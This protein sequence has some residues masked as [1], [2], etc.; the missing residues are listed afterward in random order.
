LLDIV[1]PVPIRNVLLVPDAIDAI[2]KNTDHPFQ[3]IVMIDGGVRADFQPLETAL[4]AYGKPW[5]LLHN[6]PAV[7]LNQ[8]IREG[9]EECREKITA[10]IGPEVRLM[11]PSWFG[12]IKQVFDREPIT[13]VIDTA[14]NTKSSTLYPVKRAQNR[15]PLPGCRFMVVQTNF[16]KKTPPY[17]EVDPAEFW[18]R[19]ASSQG[20]AAWHAGGVRYTEVEH[21][22][23]ELQ[24]RQLGAGR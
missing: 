23:H 19:M 14:P 24:V 15:P 7:G 8:S 22:D 6:N 16:A 11:D 3:L 1:M 5:K 10:I 9:L 21:E 17:G 2:E 12:K 4:A 18:S 13:G 20:G